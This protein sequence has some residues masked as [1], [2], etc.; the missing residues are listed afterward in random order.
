MGR[1]VAPVFATRVCTCVNIYRPQRSVLLVNTGSRVAQRAQPRNERANEFTISS[2]FLVNRRY[3]YIRRS[4]L[5]A[6]TNRV[7]AGSVRLKFNGMSTGT[8]S[9]SFYLPPPYHP[10]LI[11]FAPPPAPNDQSEF[12]LPGKTS[13]CI[14]V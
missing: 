10:S 9:R 6:W 13:K 5:H 8:A 3:T 2:N 4:G 1:H 11:P 12:L 7:K 14:S